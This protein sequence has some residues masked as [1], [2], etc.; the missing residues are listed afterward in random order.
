MCNYFGRFNIREK[1][2]LKWR[3][4]VYFRLNIR[5]ITYYFMLNM[6]DFFAI[7]LQMEN[8]F[9]IFCYEKLFWNS[10]KKSSPK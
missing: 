8:T 10:H 3:L 9:E 6:S 5:L 4:L 2:K 7:K 1:V